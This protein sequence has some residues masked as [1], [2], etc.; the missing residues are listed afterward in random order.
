MNQA[1]LEERSIEKVN[2]L[3]NEGVRSQ[4]Y[5]RSRTRKANLFHRLAKKSVAILDVILKVRFSRE[6]RPLISRRRSE[7]WK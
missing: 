1:F 6:K 7:N 2:D 4:E 3:I 5:H